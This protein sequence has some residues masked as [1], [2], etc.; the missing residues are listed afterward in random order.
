MVHCSQSAK[1]QYYS[2]HTG[3]H[4]SS[5]KLSRLFNNSL[6]HFVKGKDMEGWNEGTEKA[7]VY[8]R[9][10]PVVMLFARF[11]DYSV[12]Q[13]LSEQCQELMELTSGGV[14]AREWSKEI[15]LLG[16]VIY[17]FLCLLSQGSTLGQSFCS[18]KPFPVHFQTQGKE[19]IVRYVSKRRLLWAAFLYSALPYLYSKKAQI[20][21]IM[22][23]V[24]H[25]IRSPE[26]QLALPSQLG[27]QEHEANEDS[28]RNRG[29]ENANPDLT[30]FSQ[31][32]RRPLAA[33]VTSALYR[34]FL[35]ISSEASIRLERI[36]SLGNDL[37]LLL[38]TFSSK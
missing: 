36:C 18:I 13:A 25:I 29:L 34:S 12:V 19:Q 16:S 14:F 15:E 38:F 26:E 1:N 33:I 3:I 17:Y 11:L 32:V 27:N 2:V 20:W 22:S 31:S 8:Y 4:W 10:N 37:H 35:S 5:P 9:A 6:S 7:S 28:Y 24:W 23:S 21:S 30:S